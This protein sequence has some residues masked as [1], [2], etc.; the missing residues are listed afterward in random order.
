MSGRIFDI[1]STFCI[2]RGVYLIIRVLSRDESGVCFIIRTLIKVW[3]R[4]LFDKPK[5]V[6]RGVYLIMWVWSNAWFQMASGGFRW[7][8]VV[9]GG[10]R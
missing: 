4:R 6:L 5:G 3:G 7:F 8:Q 2:G 10:F 9:S 1:S